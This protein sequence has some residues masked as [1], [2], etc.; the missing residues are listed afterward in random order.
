MISADAGGQGKEIP[1]IIGSA[2]GCMKPTK[3]GKYWRSV[4]SV[5]RRIIECE[6]QTGVNMELL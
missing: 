5:N 1:T 2:K 3:H 4:K 6:S